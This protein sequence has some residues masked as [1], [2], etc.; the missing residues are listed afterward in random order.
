MATAI[1]PVFSKGLAI[2]SKVETP[3]HFLFNGSHIPLTA[4]TPILTPV[5]EPGPFDI[6]R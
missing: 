2:A 4:E 1:T 3:T 6:A 5:N